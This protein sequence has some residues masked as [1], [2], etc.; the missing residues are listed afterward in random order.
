MV[1]VDAEEGQGSEDEGSAP[2]HHHQHL[3]RGQLQPLLQ[4]DRVAYCVPGNEK[5]SLNLAVAKLALYAEN[6]N[7]KHCEE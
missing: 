2:P 3:A 7:F 5:A 4:L 6:N 1:G